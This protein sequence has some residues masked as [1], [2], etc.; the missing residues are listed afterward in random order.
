MTGLFQIAP[1][2]VTFGPL[3]AR[4]GGRFFETR[5]M[6]QDQAITNARERLEVILARAKRIRHA[7]DGVASPD[8]LPAA[9]LAHEMG[10]LGGD[11]VTLS[12]SLMQAARAEADSNAKA[13][14]SAE[15]RN[16]KNAAQ[17]A[18]DMRRRGA[19]SVIA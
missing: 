4:D 7:L 13:R 17:L 10:V 18:A 1:Q 3:S 11:L 16:R 9:E 6:Q 2:G 19:Y 15:R 5:A 14:S 12:R 8:S